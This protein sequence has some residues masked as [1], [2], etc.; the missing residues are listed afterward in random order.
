MQYI[1]DGLVISMALNSGHV[2]TLSFGL[3][4]L[5]FTTVMA[6][7]TFSSSGKYLK[8]VILELLSLL[9]YLPV[10]ISP[11]WLMTIHM[12]EE[13]KEYE[14]LKAEH[15][16]TAKEYISLVKKETQ[17]YEDSLRESSLR[18]QMEED[19]KKLR[20]LERRFDLSSEN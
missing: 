2:V 4:V 18:W 14:L 19:E 20:Q 3:A 15:G 6:T 13:I 12:S 8:G 9:I 1:F 7:G 5:V 17:E 10:C 11:L 16:M